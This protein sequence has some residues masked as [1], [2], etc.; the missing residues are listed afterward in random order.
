MKSITVPSY[1]RSCLVDNDRSSSNVD[2]SGQS[3]SQAWRQEAS[4][5]SARQCEEVCGRSGKDRIWNEVEYLLGSLDRIKAQLTDG[6]DW[7]RGEIDW[8]NERYRIC[9]Q[10]ALDY[11]LCLNISTVLETVS[12]PGEHLTYLEVAR[13]VVVDCSEWELGNAI[14]QIGLNP[15]ERVYYKA[16]TDLV[17][18]EMAEELLLSMLADGEYVLAGDFTKEL[19]LPVK[20][21]T[22]TALKKELVGRGWKWYSKKVEGKVVKAISR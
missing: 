5:G 20:S 19:A 4:A 22:Y 3:S 12:F 11:V 18:V 13:R 21:A 15:H 10:R 1:G 6:T 9:R 2:G 16:R 17:S 8:I 14:R 7:E